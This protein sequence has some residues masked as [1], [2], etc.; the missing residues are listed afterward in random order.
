MSNLFKPGCKMTRRTF[1]AGSVAMGASLTLFGLLDRMTAEA[2]GIKTGESG[3]LSYQ[4]CPRNCHDT[5]TLISKVVDGRIVNITGDPTHPITA[6]TPCVK[7]HCYPTWVYHPDRILY[8]MKR[9]GKKGEGNWERISWDEAY[10]TITD[11]FKA[12]IESDGAKAILPYSYS[13]NLGIVN[14]YGGPNRFWNKLGAS[15]LDRAVCAGAGSVATNYT[16]GQVGS[17]DPETYSKT[18]LF[19]SW[20]VNHTATNVHIIKFINRA[21]DNGAK[22]VE[23]NP[24]RTPL[25]SQADIHIQPKPGTDA[26]LAL[27]IMN[28]IINEGLY[29]K[30]FVENYT[31]GFDKL[32]EKVQNYPVEQVEQITGVPAATIVEFAR[33][34]A[35]TKPSIIRVGYG[36]QR[37]SNGGRMVRAISLLPALVGMVGVDGGGYIYINGDYW[38]YDWKALQRPDL[39]ADSKVRS[40]NMNEI[41]KALNGQTKET[42]GMPVKALFVYN[43]NPLAMSTNT[44]QIKQGLE[45]ED[46]FTVVVDPFIT[47]TGDYADILLPAAT[48]FEYEDI[49][50][51]YL[52]WYVRLNQ[53]AIPA[54]GE[55]KS[56]LEIFAELANRMGFTEPC[57]GDTAADIIKAGLKSGSPLFEGITY[58]TLKDKHWMKLKLDIPFADRK[59][60]TPSGKI[61]FYSE[62]LGKAGFDP[63]AEHVPPAEGSEETPELYNKYPLHFLTPATKHFITTQFHNLPYI[64]E[65]YD[66]PLVYINP[67]DAEDR[68]IESGDWVYAFNDRGK[69]KLKVRVTEGVKPGVAMSPKA[70]WQ[71]LSPGKTNVNALAPDRLG[72]MGGVSTYHTNLVQV[73]KKI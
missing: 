46:L 55:S 24:V 69:V 13:G 56:N 66:G 4:A 41:G 73:A 68:G 52:G 51:D 14:N 70:P 61:E 5:C 50:S 49:N 10:S 16:Y 37:S 1:L 44:N 33:L 32:V 18:K 65:I 43:S 25:G 53:P 15:K 35:T 47:D 6:G 17:I 29:D 42:E 30:S 62:A 63:V 38:A 21:R 67:K 9:A 34:Y 3:I 8:P 19:V 31:L 23:I 27:G 45:R 58:E 36:M 59:F 64:Q 12:I 20:G 22:L 2:S 11:K 40:I 60:K 48:F 39:L 72:D 57:F 54:L 26:A 7:G 28:V 71:K